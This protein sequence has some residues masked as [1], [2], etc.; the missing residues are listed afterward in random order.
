MPDPDALFELASPCVDVCTLD[1]ATGYCLGCWR[2]MDEIADWPGLDHAGRVAV[3][4]RLQ[5]RRQAAG[6]DRRR[7]TRR[8]RQRSEQ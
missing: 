1:V 2:T 4:A 5:Q 6:Q 8:R 7:V 3:L